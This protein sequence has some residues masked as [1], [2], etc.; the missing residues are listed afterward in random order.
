MN[1]AY[2]KL[3]LTLPISI[4]RYMYQNLVLYFFHINWNDDGTAHVAVHEHRTIQV[5]VS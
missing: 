2:N 3:L 5:S 1:I 4:A